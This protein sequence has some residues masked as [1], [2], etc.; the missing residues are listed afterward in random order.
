[1]YHTCIHVQKNVK[2]TFIDKKSASGTNN[3]AKKLPLI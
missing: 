1:M 3:Y 2:M